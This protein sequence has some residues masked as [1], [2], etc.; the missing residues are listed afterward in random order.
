MKVLFRVDASWTIGTGHVIRC[1]TLANAFRDIGIE[2]SFICR[3]HE[4]NCISQIQQSGYEVKVLIKNN[5]NDKFKKDDGL[6]LEHESWLGVDWQVDVAEVIENITAS[7]SP[8]WLIVDHYG[9]DFRWERALRAYCR[10]M[11][12]IDDLADRSHD[13]DL[14]LDQNLVPNMKRRYDTLIN[15]DAIRLLGPRYAL[16]QPQYINSRSH[17]LVR[18]SKIKRIF[19]FM[20]GSDIYNLT[21]K[22]IQSFIAIERPDIQLDVVINQRASYAR[23]LREWLQSFKNIF[24][25]EALPSLADLIKNAD[26]SIGAAG[27]VTWERCCLGLPSL[28][29][30]MAENQIPTAKELHR[31]GLVRYIGRHDSVTNSVI[32]NELLK[33]LE[34]DDFRQWSQSCMDLVD[35]GGTMRVINA[36]IFDPNGIFKAR[37]VNIDDDALLLEWRNDVEVRKN[38]FSETA[39]DII[40]HQKWFKGVLNNPNKHAIYIIETENGFPLGQVRFDLLDDVWIINYSIDE[41]ARGRKFGR[42]FL[43]VAIEAFKHFIG[44]EVDIIGYVKL[45]NIASQKVF[46]SLGFLSIKGDVSCYQKSLKF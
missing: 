7:I 45:D 13:C 3:P 4:G 21:T 42:N 40:S 39:I 16:L 36:I 28:V 26:I 31:L 29:I 5:S 37:R 20:G 10:R 30:S 27:T 34:V 19:V 46:E 9:L 38:S 43:N 8:D 24:L 14:L 15:V 41:F 1:L 23:G 2:S 12:V 32:E 25:H 18:K 11:M 17:A 22:I 33:I 44:E 6:P 35:G